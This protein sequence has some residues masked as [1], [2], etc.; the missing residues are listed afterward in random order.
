MAFSTDFSG[1][2]SL[3]Q[4]YATASIYVNGSLLAEE[5]SINITRD[6]HSESIHT[7]GAGYAGEMYGSPTVEVMVDSAVPAAGFEMDPGK[8]M[9]A[10]QEITF[11]VFANSTILSFT[12]F[13]VSDNFAHA[14]NSASK[15]SFKAKGSIIKVGYINKDSLV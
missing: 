1:P 7:V 6:A 14:V 4:L 13:I 10:M 9:G 15:L 12:G 11:S 5:T 3:L 8:F 2:V